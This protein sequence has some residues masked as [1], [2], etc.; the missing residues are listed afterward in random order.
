MA[1]PILHDNQ[2]SMYR[3]CLLVRCVLHFACRCC[4][5]ADLADL[6]FQVSGDVVK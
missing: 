1:A 5:V 2:P 6:L 3:R 4:G